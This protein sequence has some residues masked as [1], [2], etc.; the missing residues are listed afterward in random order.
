[1]NIE[2]SKSELCW[3]NI[4]MDVCGPHVNLIFKNFTGI[5]KF[6]KNAFLLLCHVL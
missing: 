4:N 6:K 5:L 2:W 1:M 3:H